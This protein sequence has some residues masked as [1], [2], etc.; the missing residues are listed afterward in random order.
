MRV[1][2]CGGAAAARQSGTVD[3]KETVF[4]HDPDFKVPFRI[5][6]DGGEAGRFSLAFLTIETVMR[7]A[8]THI[9]VAV[10]HTLPF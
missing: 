7:V 6:T 9:M 1:Q 3:I 5:S 2:L 10:D 4:L 8:D